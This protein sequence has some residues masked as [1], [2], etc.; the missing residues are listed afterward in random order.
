MNNEK[1]LKEVIKITREAERKRVLELIDNEIDH[2]SP[3]R[4]ITDS[5]IMIQ[6]RKVLDELKHK[7]FSEED[8]K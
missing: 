8:L 5:E 1:I 7:I 2:Y 4:P 6:S 3:Y